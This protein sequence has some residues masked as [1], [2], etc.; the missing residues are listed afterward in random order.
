MSQEIILVIIT[1]YEEVDEEEYAS[2]IISKNKR[3]KLNAKLNK[4]P[5]H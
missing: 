2:P 1:S 4:Y 3:I 5:Q